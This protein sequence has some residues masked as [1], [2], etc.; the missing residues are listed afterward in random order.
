MSE[1]TSASE[2]FLGSIAFTQG[3]EKTELGRCVAGKIGSAVAQKFPL[4]GSKKIALENSCLMY[5]SYFS[6]FILKIV[7]IYFLSESI[8]KSVIVLNF[9]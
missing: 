4:V 9:I 2:I 3:A 1:F 6:D 8:L 5:S 7:I